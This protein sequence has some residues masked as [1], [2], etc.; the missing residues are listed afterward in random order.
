MVQPAAAPGIGLFL[1]KGALVVVVL[2]TDSRSA[3][4]ASSPS[5][6]FRVLQRQGAQGQSLHASLLWV[7]E[8]HREV[9]DCL[10]VGVGMQVAFLIP[11]EVCSTAA[12]TWT[13]RLWEATLG[14][15]SKMLPII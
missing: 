13:F 14:S 4:Q 7:L 8:L 6:K 1:R 11:W 9:L 10:G 12:S 15:H 3:S 2:R 5:L